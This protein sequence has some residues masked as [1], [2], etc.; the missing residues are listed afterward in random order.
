LTEYLPCHVLNVFIPLIDITDAEGPT[1]FRPE[2][3]RLTLDL[4]KLYL[5]AFMTKT[6]RPTVKPHLKKGSALLVSL[7]LSPFFCLSLS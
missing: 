5:R 1:E 6:L 4:Q 2:S 7:S 3:Q